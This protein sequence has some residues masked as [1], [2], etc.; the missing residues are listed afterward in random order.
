MGLSFLGI[1]MGQ[2]CF[3]FNQ[4]SQKLV[5]VNV[6]NKD[7]ILAEQS[8]SM[9]TLIQLEYHLQPSP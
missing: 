7:L 4:S 8:M 2:Q 5:V 6:R 1:S 3:L 9:R